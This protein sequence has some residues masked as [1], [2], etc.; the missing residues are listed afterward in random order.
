VFLVSVLISLWAFGPLLQPARKGEAEAVVNRAQNAARNALRRDADQAEASIGDRD[1]RPQCHLF[2]TARP[3]LANADLQAD[4]AR[5]N[6]LDAARAAAVLNDRDRADAGSID[7]HAL[8]KTRG[9]RDGVRG[10][11]RHRRGEHRHQE[12]KNRLD[13]HWVELLPEMKRQCDRR[14]ARAQSRTVC[15]FPWRVSAPKLKI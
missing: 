13:A 7:D 1:G 12:D 6:A 11:G 2:H 4:L 3:T 10:S 5:P 8:A 15:R 14:A 9:D